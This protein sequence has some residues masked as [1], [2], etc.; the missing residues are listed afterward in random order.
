MSSALGTMSELL[1]A[2]FDL[3]MLT[4]VK[5]VQEVHR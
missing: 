4:T 1:K 3:H 5:A 2:P